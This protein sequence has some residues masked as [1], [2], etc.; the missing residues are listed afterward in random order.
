MCAAYQAFTTEYRCVMPSLSCSALAC[1]CLAP[2]FCVDPYNACQAGGGT[3][4]DVSCMC[5][6]C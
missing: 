4:V 5:P 6:A 3:G 1:S 2:Y